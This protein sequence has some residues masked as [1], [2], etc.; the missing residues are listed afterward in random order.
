MTPS[1]GDALGPNSV[2][3]THGIEVAAK[4]QL[5]EQ[6]TDPGE[7]GWIYAYQITIT[8]VGERPLTLRTRHWVITDANG[9]RREVRGP[10]VV[11]EQPRLEPGD[12]FEYQSM[13]ELKTDWGTMEGGYAFISDEGEELEVSVG[14]FFLAESVANSIIDS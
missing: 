4:A 11:G 7:R 6:R 1:S 5:L 2:T 9:E 8:N 14:R 10:G 12:H 13:A 3:T